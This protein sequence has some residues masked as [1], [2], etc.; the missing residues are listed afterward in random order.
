ME[1]A[2]IAAA[3][4]MLAAGSAGFIGSIFIF[5]NLLNI[6]FWWMKS[7]LVINQFIMKVHDIDA[8]NNLL[9]GSFF[10]FVCYSSINAFHLNRRVGGYH[11]SLCF[12]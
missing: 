1:T 7:G 12:C 10:H 2:A 5:S 6:S 9:L 4:T 11:S 8:A 3:N